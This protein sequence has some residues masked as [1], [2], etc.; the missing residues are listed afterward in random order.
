MSATVS[1][2]GA[3]KPAA[4]PARPAYFDT[5]WTNGHNPWA[6][7]LVVTMATF[8]EVLDTSIANVSLPHIA[9]NLSVSQDESTWVLTSYLV[10]NAVVLPISGWIAS[11]IGRKRFYMIC[12]M[13]FTTSSFLCGVAPSLGLLIFFR[14]VQGLGG[15]GLGP[16]EQAILADTFPPAKRGM[17]FAVYGMAVVLAPAIG[18][19]LGGFITDHFNWRWIFFINVPVGLVSLFLTQRL[20]SD[21]PHIR[22]AKEKTGGIDYIGLGLIAVGLGCLEIVLDKGQEDDWFTS[23]FILVMSV[24]AG[25]TLISFVIWESKQKNPVVDVNMFKDRTFAVSNVMMLVLGIA[26]F[27]STVLLPQYTQVIMGYSAQQAGMALSP[28]GFVVIM[29]LPF[30]GFLVSRVDARYLIGFGFVALSASMFYMSGHLYEGID[31]RTAVELRVLQSIGMPFLFIPINT[32][33]YSG[34]PPQKNN[35]VSGIVNLSRNMGGDIGIAF[36]TTLVSRRVQFHQDALVARTSGYDATFMSR[37][38]GVAR[39]L[40]HAGASSV[41]AATKALHVLYFQVQRQ[42]MTLAYLDAIKM[43]AY[44]TAAMLPLLFLARR[45]RAGGAPAGH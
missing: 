45:P 19:T 6:I 11:K 37:M 8:M 44:F 43:L 25:V 7:A 21:P 12:V 39:T 1:G 14:V 24:I 20:V 22:A 36:V 16:S 30:V 26:L 3:A 2:N 4:A 33:V 35:A 42:A 40:E 5:G 32:L 34:V 18:P 23:P 29:I 28:G 9:G 15:G 31:F 38:G 41:D 13:V 27:G 10:S 17:A